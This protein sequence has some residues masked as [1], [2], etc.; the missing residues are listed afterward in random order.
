MAGIWLNVFLLALYQI[1]PRPISYRSLYAKY[2]AA[3]LQM[4]TERSRSDILHR[5][6]SGKFSQVFS[7]MDSGYS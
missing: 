3:F 6:D 5:V 2:L 7:F 4:E 1:W